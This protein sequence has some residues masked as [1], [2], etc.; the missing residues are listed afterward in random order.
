MNLRAV[1]W[2]LGCVLCILAVMLLVPAGVSLYY[3]E[4]SV[5]RACLGSAAVTALLGA[6]VVLRYRGAIVTKHGR[7]DYFRREGL[8]AVGLS[9]FAAAIVGAL[10]FMLSGA[11]DSP[12]D[13]FFESASGFTTTGATILS[14]EA[15]D[16][17][18]LGITFWRSFTHWLGGIGIVL[19]FVLL[20]P[21]GGR[22]LFRS[23]VPG[24]SRE[25]VQQ[26]VRDSAMG[27]VRI[28]VG[29][30]VACGVLL[31]AAGLSP[32]E[33]VLHSFGTLATGGFSNHSA[34]IAYFASVKV[35]LVL[36]LF[37]FAAGINFAFYDVLLRQSPRAAL[38]AAMR[39]EE[40]RVYT[41]L[42]AGSILLLTVVLWFWGG[43]N[44]APES[45][46][47]DYSSLSLSLRDTAF[48]VLSVQTSTGYATA[49]FDRWP[50]F[51]RM[52]LMLLAFTGACA[53]ST[54]GGLKV[55]RFLIL[56]KASL[57]GF[58]RFARPRAIHAVR[59]DGVTVE[60]SMVASITGYFGMWAI[61]FSLGSLAMSAFGMDLET[62]TTAVLACL[63]N[64][65]P[66]LNAVGPTLNFGEMP[67][68]A[69]AILSVFMVLGRL[70]FYA[71]VVLFVPSF[72]RH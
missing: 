39:S 60:D 21:T 49:D 7:A 17:L 1:A 55:M 57:R 3:G 37:M 28:Y 40:V 29:L 27:L 18:P 48:T 14:G 25:A 16:G 62:A 42:I 33:S 22:S 13:A 47:P 9:W 15:I 12:V 36:I 68:L 53:G 31:M 59:V 70:E 67:A 50:Q 45:D 10:P 32:F 72:W 56:A 52:L 41:G 44:G 34:S 69:K 26:R 35:E 54:G 5:M 38:R 2:L 11:I 6:L 71:V 64:I 46:L 61:I 43:S 4:I 63:N 23:E 51:A 19:V 20:F 66:G 58:K 30:T 24:V 8:A 65:G